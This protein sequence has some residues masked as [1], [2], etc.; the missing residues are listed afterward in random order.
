MAF[1]KDIKKP[2]MI[3]DNYRKNLIETADYLIKVRINLFGNALDMKLR[4]KQ[5]C[6]K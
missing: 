2:L 6:K 3:E 4:N 1:K 5:I